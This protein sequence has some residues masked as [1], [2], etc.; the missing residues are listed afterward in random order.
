MSIIYFPFAIGS[1]IKPGRVAIRALA[2]G[3]QAAFSVD[4]Y[5]NGKPVT[6]ERL[7]FNSRFGKLLESELQ[8]YLHEGDPGPRTESPEGSGFSLEEMKKEASRC[9][10]C[11][12]R[13]LADCKLR[14]YADEYEAVQKRYFPIL[15]YLGRNSTKQYVHFLWMTASLFSL[16]K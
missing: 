5:L 16:L 11:D 14:I 6:G 8:E 9:M 1:A 2:H 7:M 13:K 12:C 15:L 10:H 3:K 4:Q